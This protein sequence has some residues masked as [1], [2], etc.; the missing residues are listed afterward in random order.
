MLGAVG[1]AFEQQEH[2]LERALPPTCSLYAWK[3]EF[4][5]GEAGVPRGGLSREERRFRAQNER[6]HI[7]DLQLRS[8]EIMFPD[9]LTDCLQDCMRAS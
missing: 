5:F 7:T 1:C 6:G 4:C 3:A 9:V 8:G 2:L